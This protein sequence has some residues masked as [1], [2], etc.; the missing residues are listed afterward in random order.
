MLEESVLN[1][2][3]GLSYWSDLKEREHTIT[4]DLAHTHTSFTRAL[5]KLCFPGFWLS[6]YSLVIGPAMNR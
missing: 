4:P 6:P 2:I 5:N 1:L 3:I